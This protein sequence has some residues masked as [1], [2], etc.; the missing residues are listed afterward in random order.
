MLVVEGYSII[1]IMVNVL[2]ALNKYLVESA[3]KAWKFHSKK[4]QL[5]II[6]L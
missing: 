2:N 3:Y 5:K 6:R 4:I 1:G